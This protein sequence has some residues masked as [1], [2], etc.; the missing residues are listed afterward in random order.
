[1]TAQMTSESVPRVWSASDDLS[2]RVKRLRDEYFAFETRQFRNE[3]L[4]FSTG[5]SWDAVYSYSRWTV[6]P[7]ACAVNVA[8][9]TP[10][11]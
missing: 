3:V 4:P 6:A 10:P 7:H 9:S 1:M 11:V 5:T 2:D 8:L